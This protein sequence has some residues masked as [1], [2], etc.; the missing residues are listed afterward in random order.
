MPQRPKSWRL[1]SATYLLP[2]PQIMSTGSKTPIPKAI[3]AIAGTPPTMKMRSAPALC[4]ALMVA[5]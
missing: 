1:A 3:I 5:R 4:M 2:A